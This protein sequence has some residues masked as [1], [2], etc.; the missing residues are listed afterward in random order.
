[1][2]ASSA[3]ISRRTFDES[4]RYV[5][6]IL[7]QGVPVVDS[8]VNEGQES[9]YTQLRRTIVNSI[10]DGARGDGFL[11]SAIPADNNFT[12][13][14]DDLVD[15]GPETLYVKGHQAQLLADETYQAADETAPVSVGFQTDTLTNDTLVDTAAD[16]TPGALVGKTLTPNLLDPGTTFTITANTANTIK[17][18]A[19]M[20]PSPGRGYQI[21]LT[22]PG[23]DRTDLVYVD[24]YLDE[25]DS[26]EDL[27]LKHT[28][29][30][31]QFESTR[32]WKV[33]QTVRVE[34]G[35]TLPV[36][37][38][39]GRTDADGNRH[40]LLP[41]A[42]INREGGNAQITSSMIVDLRPKIFTLEEIEARFVNAAG[43]TMTG[44]LVM[45]ADIVMNAGQRVIG[46]CVIDSDALCPEAVQ[47]RHFDRNEHLLGD[48]GEVPTFSEVNDP[49]DPKFF[50]VH[51]NRYYTKTE[52]DNLI[53]TNTIN[54][55]LF[56][57]GFE[58]WENA[59]PQP[60]VG[61]PA[62]EAA[63]SVIVSLGLCST[64]CG[65]DCACRTLNICA[66][67]GSR[68]CF[69]CPIRQEVALRCG[70]K[71]VLVQTL[72]VS[73][74]D[75]AVRPYFLLDM[76]A[77]CQF[78]GTIKVDM[79]E[80]PSDE[81]NKAGVEASDGFTR[82]E[83]QVIVPQCVDQVFLT[84]CYDVVAQAALG[85][86]ENVSTSPFPPS[87]PISPVSPSPSAG[88]LAAK[89]EVGPE[90]LEWS[91]CSLQMRRVTGVEAEFTSLG[92]NT[93]AEPVIE[94]CDVS[95][96][97]R[98]VTYTP[99]QGQVLTILERLE[100]KIGGTPTGTFPTDFPGVDLDPANDR[101]VDE[102]DVFAQV[103]SSCAC[104]LNC[105][106]PGGPL[107]VPTCFLY[108]PV[109]GNADF[110]CPEIT[111]EALGVS[112][113]GQIELLLTRIDLESGPIDFL[114]LTGADEDNT[115]LK[116]T[117]GRNTA[118]IGPDLNFRVVCVD[119]EGRRVVYGFENE[120]DAT[121]KTVTI[122][123]ADF[124]R[125]D[126]SAFDWT[127]V[128]IIYVGYAIGLVGEPCMFG[129]DN[130][131]FCTKTDA[132]TYSFGQ[133]VSV[134][135]H[136]QEAVD[137]DC[138]S[139]EDF[140]DDET[141]G[142]PLDRI[143]CN[144]QFPLGTT[145]PDP[146][147]DFCE[148]VAAIAVEGEGSGAVSFE[149]GTGIQASAVA[150]CRDFPTTPLDL[151]TEVSP[152]RFSVAVDANR[153]GTT[154]W[155]VAYSGNGGAAVEEFTLAGG[156][157]TLDI[158]WVTAF[159]GLPVFDD[160]DIV[161]ICLFFGILEGPQLGDIY[162]TDNWQVDRTGAGTG[163]TLFEGWNDADQAAL[164]A[165]L[166]SGA[167]RCGYGEGLLL[168]NTFAVGSPFDADTTPLVAL[169]A[170]RTKKIAYWGQNEATIR[171][172]DV[173]LVPAKY[174]SDPVV[175]EDGS[176]GID[177][178]TGL[179]E[180]GAEAAL[181]RDT[182]AMWGK[183]AF[184]EAPFAGC[185]NIWCD[186][187]YLDQFECGGATPDLTEFEFFDPGCAC[188]L[189]G[190][191]LDVSQPVTDDCMYRLLADD[192]F[193]GLPSGYPE[194][195]SFEYCALP[196]L[197]RNEG[198]GND[199]FD[200]IRETPE[201]AR[202]DGAYLIR[203]TF[204]AKADALS[205]DWIDTLPAGHTLLS[206]KLSDTVLINFTGEEATVEY[207]VKT[208]GPGSPDATINGNAELTGQP[209]TNITLA[210]DPIEITENCAT[211]CFRSFGSQNPEVYGKVFY[212]GGGR[213]DPIPAA[214]D[215]LYVTTYLGRGSAGTSA[216]E[217]F[218][219]TNTTV[220]DTATSHTFRILPAEIGGFA[221]GRPVWVFNGCFPDN[222]QRRI[223]VVDIE[224]EEALADPDEEVT[225]LY[226]TI[227]AVDAVLGDI[228]VTFDAAVAAAGGVDFTTTAQAGIMVAPSN[229]K[230]FYWEANENL[231][232]LCRGFVGVSQ[233]MLRYDYR[234]WN[235]TKYPCPAKLGAA[236]VCDGDGETDVFSLHGDVVKDIINP[237]DWIALDYTAPIGPHVPIKADLA[238]TADT[239]AVCDICIFGACDII[240]IVDDNCSGA[241]GNGPGFV[242]AV[243]STTP[244]GAETCGT[245]PTAEGD[246]E[247]DPAIPSDIVGCPGFTD[248]TTAADGIAF[249]K[250][251]VCRLTL[252]PTQ[253]VFADG[254]PVDGPNFVGVN[255]ETG[256]LTFDRSVSVKNPLVCYRK[257]E[258][259]VFLPP[260]EGIYFLV[261]VDQSGRR[262]P[263][264][265]PI[266]VLTP[267]VPEDCGIG[268]SPKLLDALFVEIGSVGAGPFFGVDAG[269][270]DM[271]FTVVADE[272]CKVQIEVNIVS[273][274]AAMTLLDSGGTVSLQLIKD[275]LGA[276]ESF[277]LKQ[278]DHAG[279][280]TNGGV[281]YLGTTS[282][283]GA[284]FTTLVLPPGVHTFDLRIV[285]SGFVSGSVSFPM[286]I[287][288][289][290]LGAC[291][292]EPVSVGIPC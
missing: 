100:E 255:F 259:C 129:I 199:D 76:Y 207:V 198:N 210:S 168:N 276:C 248:F 45:D 171:D 253:K 179:P 279:F 224:G 241:E 74:G 186:V 113:G 130:L 206:G 132:S 8:D 166:N 127:Q 249:V 172:A 235:S 265:K 164:N 230:G 148:Q 86:P 273:M 246:V 99:G 97:Q 244:T 81:P 177:P 272:Q 104:L 42:L 288:A 231:A 15:D 190:T 236:F 264:S 121:H 90:G 275:P 5:Q 78:V 155:A 262:S 281:G 55:G 27:N 229:S 30:S 96:G 152:N 124:Q 46:I 73:K 292:G 138:I 40:V 269:V 212:A 291:V 221:V 193:G 263:P 32:R 183:V 54:N 106:D 141:K 178:D 112:A 280:A 133:A 137:E 266:R 79:F 114:Q 182:G 257:L 52:I 223:H 105:N 180:A 205:I 153:A 65:T 195:I 154:L 57:N 146:D 1:M 29:S 163:P 11:I 70:G 238:P 240:Q 36:T 201:C 3:S 274:V 277:L 204:R 10:G 239:V 49:L 268:Q 83:Q 89:C 282:A 214:E 219:I 158:D 161:R 271:P 33:V 286:T 191:T 103:V 233:C 159:P 95:G 123:L 60:L 94:S 9:A 247:F 197:D 169:N 278:V 43:D 37:L 251:D 136:N 12:I 144:A 189:P 16:Y 215:G 135:P 270:P 25:I 48:G 287:K 254:T 203:V 208:P 64:L 188:V 109:N 284:A 22:T 24:V 4:N 194:S 72:C 68:V 85:T 243:V 267:P 50:N 110:G 151:T 82:L 34:E 165:R 108:G 47:Q 142:A 63:T 211:L 13:N 118:G 220:A 131:R 126:A 35:I 245:D 51:D 111:D 283:G 44:P 91:V 38:P 31:V 128:A 23:A 14:G 143:T 56:D 289:W 139:L 147:T 256:L 222:P 77:S 120:A 250:P 227:T 252:S 87:P 18:G 156:A 28:V 225:G 202:P 59:I 170:D 145:P 71:F 260:D 116:F 157:E 134:A 192:E 261:G 88:D 117:M 62:A 242:G 61:A 58:G 101:C 149:V 162:Q 41:I 67:P 140:G 93:T 125:L 217:A 234:F 6:L 285:T 228:T 150:F 237:R 181:A 80:P 226:G 196:R 26:T 175:G 119:D 39:D 98:K 209:L 19:S 107:A 102:M 21:A 75:E 200:F 7:Q 213:T 174:R 184:T 173:V 92:G 66:L 20:T 258:P 167:V 176:G 218:I 122:P 2:G 53:G 84:P 17:V 185:R 187:V 232:D 160:T 115:A 216:R 69:I 290:K